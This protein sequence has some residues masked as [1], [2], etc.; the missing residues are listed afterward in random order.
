MLADKNNLIPMALIP[1]SIGAHR[2]L[3]T[4]FSVSFRVGLCLE[5]K[6]VHLAAESHGKHRRKTN[7]EDLFI[8]R[9]RT[10]ML[11]DKTI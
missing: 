8:S 11:A 10:Q 9:E 6:T 3:K 7:P 2:R 1:A 4:P 5:S